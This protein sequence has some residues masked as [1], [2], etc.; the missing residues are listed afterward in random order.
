MVAALVGLDHARPSAGAALALGLHDL[1]V[2][3]GLLHEVLHLLDQG[4]KLVHGA[5]RHKLANPLGHLRVVPA[6]LHVVR[7]K[8]VVAHVV[9]A[10]L[11]LGEVAG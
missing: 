2:R 5:L 6:H 7:D 10:V 11:S 8:V 1:D 3:R 4:S 9:G